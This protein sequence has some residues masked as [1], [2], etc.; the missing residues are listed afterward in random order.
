MKVE[1][2]LTGNNQQV[3]SFKIR[4][5]NMIYT[6]F[7]K[8]LPSDSPDTFIADDVGFLDESNTELNATDIYNLL[9]IC[10]V[11]EAEVFDDFCNDISYSVE[12]KS[13]KFTLSDGDEIH[14]SD[15]QLRNFQNITVPTL[16]CISKA[17]YNQIAE[18]V[19][20]QTRLDNLQNAIDN[21]LNEDWFGNIKIVLENAVKSD[22]E[23]KA[24]SLE[25]SK[26]EDYSG[27]EELQILNQIITKRGG[28][29][30]YIVFS[31]DMVQRCLL[32]KTIGD[33][34]AENVRKHVGGVETIIKE[35]EIMIADEFGNSVD[36]YFATNMQFDCMEVL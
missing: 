19:Q 30:W 5:D 31:D 11:C 22:N 26:V 8:E 12:L 29:A 7:F 3:A 13:V 16:G 17:Q 20:L 1:M 23:K 18:F 4:T 14:L 10:S 15:F 2:R 28:M 25:W 36:L 6:M 33:I 32:M 21:I 24:I 34:Y 35:N 27:E 9:R